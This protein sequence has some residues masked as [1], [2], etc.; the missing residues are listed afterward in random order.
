MSKSKA[1]RSRDKILRAATS[2]FAEK[3]FE[4]ASMDDIVQASGVSKGGIYWHFKSKDEM[5]AA[6]FRELFEQEIEQMAALVVA[7]G[8][9]SERLAH[10]MRAS[11]ADVQALDAELPFTLEIYAQAARQEAL[12]EV[13]QAYFSRYHA[14]LT[15]LVAQGV[16]QGEFRPVDPADTAL[17][18][19]S[20]F[21]GLLLL[22]VFSHDALDLSRQVEASL[23]LLL[24][25]IGPPPTQ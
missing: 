7:G 8:S 14:M 16:A 25:G 2:V 15:E 23:S 1:Q 19:M 18:L 3:G 9:A 21:E 20:L 11:V 5:I 4:A 10:I 6:V 13:L 22:W 17:T 24:A 12:G